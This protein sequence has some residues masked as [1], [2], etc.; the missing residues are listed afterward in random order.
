MSQLKLNVEG[1]HCK[2][3]VMLVQDSLSEIGAENVKIELDEK[4]KKAAVSCDYDR[5]KMDIINIIKKE[6]YRVKR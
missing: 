2:S 6:G 4:T 5:D 1:M 3:C